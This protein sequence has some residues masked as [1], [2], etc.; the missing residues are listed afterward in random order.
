MHVLQRVQISFYRQRTYIKFTM[1]N[2][3]R[4]NVLK[5]AKRG[6]SPIILNCVICHVRY[7]LL[8]FALHG[9]LEE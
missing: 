2:A 9:I 8:P 5:R 6:V 3:Q 1:S 4:Q 7:A